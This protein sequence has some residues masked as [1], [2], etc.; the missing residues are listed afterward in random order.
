MVNRIHSEDPEDEEP[1]LDI[2]ELPQVIQD[3]IKDLK[4][5]EG[6]EDEDIKIISMT[7]IPKNDSDDL[8]NHLDL[9]TKLKEKMESIAEEKGIDLKDP[10]TG[11]DAK[12]I[13]VDQLWDMHMD[14]F[15]PNGVTPSSTI[16]GEIDLKF[17][18]MV[19][20]I[21]A[22]ITLKTI[23]ALSQS[24][25]PDDLLSYFVDSFEQN[26]VESCDSLQSELFGD[27][28]P[29]RDWTKP[30]TKNPENN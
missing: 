4:E 19:G 15:Y 25:V 24:G 22:I 11:D 18:F 29:K 27:T 30:N 13:K 8:E 20:M 5:K 14:S 6:L 9:I 3:H 12:G 7:K 26:I 17:A 2:S 10:I 1:G 16:K 21:N 28:Q 23:N